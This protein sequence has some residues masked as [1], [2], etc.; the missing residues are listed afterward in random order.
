[1]TKDGIINALNEKFVGIKST[2]LYRTI[3]ECDGMVVSDN[4][5]KFI[6]NRET[7]Y[8]SKM[9]DYILPMIIMEIRLTDRIT[10]YLPNYTNDSVY[11]C[12]IRCNNHDGVINST[13]I[14]ILIFE[15]LI[16]KLKNA[17]IIAPLESLLFSG[18]ISINHYNSDN[19]NHVLRVIHDSNIFIDTTQHSL[20]YF[21]LLFD[22]II[23]IN[24]KYDKNNIF[25]CFS[26]VSLHNDI[27]ID[28]IKNI[29]YLHTD[30]SVNQSYLDRFILLRFIDVK[31]DYDHNLIKKYKSVSLNGVVLYGKQ[32]LIS[33][34]SVK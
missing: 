33:F 30:F 12:S 1:M 4:T 3:N 5:I 10:V 32:P 15:S 13:D 29:I 8:I 34:L 31:M 27:S 21:G 23:N 22:D 17:S 6:K 7:G 11:S 28:I 9:L 14:I 25:R 2:L 20:P 18:I 16:F 24:G 26:G 19:D